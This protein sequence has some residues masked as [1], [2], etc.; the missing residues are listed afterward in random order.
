MG[1]SEF[2]FYNE[3]ISPLRYIFHHVYILI[4]RIG[5]QTNVDNSKYLPGLYFPVYV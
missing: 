5:L 3:V 4:M 1:F 2:L